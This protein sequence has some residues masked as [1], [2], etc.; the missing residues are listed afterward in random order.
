MKLNTDKCHLIV[1]ETKHEH[2]WVKKCKDKIW[3]R[4][5]M[6][7]FDIDIDNKLKFDERISNTNLKVNKKSSALTKLSR[8]SSLEK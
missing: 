8:F 3:P 7:L 6:K 2:V 4:N 5:N 1:S